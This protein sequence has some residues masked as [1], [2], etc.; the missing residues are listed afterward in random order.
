MRIYSHYIIRTNK[1]MKGTL[2][3]NLPEEEWEFKTANASVPMHFVIKEM[4]QWLRERIKYAPDNIDV[5]TYAT[6][7]LCREQLHKLL[8][9]NDLRL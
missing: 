6:L 2:E 1:E 4:D 3:F 5:Y 9:D 7:E 8:D